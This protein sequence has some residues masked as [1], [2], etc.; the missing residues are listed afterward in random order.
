MNGTFP[1]LAR[2][3]T[4]RDQSGH[5][6]KCF[7]LRFVC[8]VIQCKTCG[9]FN[10]P[11]PFNYARYKAITLF[12]SVLFHYALLL[13]S[14]RQLYVNPWS[15]SLKKNLES[16]TNAVGKKS[17]EFNYYSF[18][19]PE[20][21]SATFR[22]FLKGRFLT[23]RFQKIVRVSVV[24]LTYNRQWCQ[25]LTSQTTLALTMTS[26]QVV[27]TSVRSVPVANSLTQDHTHPDVRL[28]S[29]Y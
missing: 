28:Y 14:L 16:G 1:E 19:I 8:Y 20:W 23:A 21:H 29:T 11:R 2:H 25:I 15:T 24:V 4:L 17:P 22:Y 7:R 5:N 13:F 9:Y 12:S 10:L 6:N 3:S 18:S 27:K 26:R